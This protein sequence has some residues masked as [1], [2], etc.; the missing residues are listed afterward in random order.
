MLASSS[1]GVVMGLECASRAHKKQGFDIAMVSKPKTTRASGGG[2]KPGNPDDLKSVRL[3]MRAHPDLVD[4]LTER[5][6][7]Y[8]VSRTEY[9]ERILIS[10][11]NL[12]EGQRPL[13]WSG[14]Y[15]KT[16]VAASI[17][18]QRPGDAWAAFGA[19][20]MRLMGIHA[21]RAAER[22]AAEGDDDDDVNK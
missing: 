5:G 10:Y 15:V 19:N 18:R 7:I 2:R 14:R 17:S 3:V 12:Q 21:E 11:L 22:A 20:N 6:K 1:G 4:A 13:D 16:E 8:G 9:V